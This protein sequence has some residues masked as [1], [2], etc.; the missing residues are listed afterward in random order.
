VSD[1]YAACLIRTSATFQTH[2]IEDRSITFELTNFLD[3]FIV[4]TEIQYNTLPFGDR[5]GLP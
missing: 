2:K 1:S 5:L 4:C 3:F